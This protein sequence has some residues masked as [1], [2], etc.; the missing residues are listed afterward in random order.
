[1]AIDRETF[2]ADLYALLAKLAE[3]DVSQIKPSDLLREDL[4]LDS[5]KSMEL[6]SRIS[7]QYDIDVD[8]EDLIEID[9]VDDIV[10]FLESYI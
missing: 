3:L 6:L 2:L 10:K 5:L 7:E 1:M 9:T 4:G 8:L